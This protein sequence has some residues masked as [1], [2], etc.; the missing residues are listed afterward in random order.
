[1]TN[2]PTAPTRSPLRHGDYRGFTVYLNGEVYDTVY[3]RTNLK[4]RAREVRE[5]L[6]NHDKYPAGIDVIPM[7]TLTLAQ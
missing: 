3:Y 4:P 7:E 6:I 2:Y 1:M 5:D